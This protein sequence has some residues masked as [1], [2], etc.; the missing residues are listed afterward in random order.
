MSKISSQRTLVLLIEYSSV[1]RLTIVALYEAVAHSKSEVS[2]RVPFFDSY[3]DVKYP[4]RALS[5]STVF[6]NCAIII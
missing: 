2:S 4:R 3:V 6:L 1:V 5:F